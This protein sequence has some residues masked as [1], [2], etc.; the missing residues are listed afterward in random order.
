MKDK[1]DDEMPELIY[2]DEQTG[3]YYDSVGNLI[4][5]NPD[6]YIIEEYLDGEGP[7][8]INM[9]LQVAPSQVGSERPKSSYSRPKSAA[10]SKGRRLAAKRIRKVAKE[11]EV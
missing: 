11:P 10:P 3:L 6:D 1:R 2:F 8:D 7:P 9:T 4:E 5:F